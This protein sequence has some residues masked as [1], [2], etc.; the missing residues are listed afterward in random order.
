MCL[1]FKHL[2]SVVRYCRYWRC[3]QNAWNFVRFVDTKPLLKKNARQYRVLL[4]VENAAVIDFEQLRSA[5]MKIGVFDGPFWTRRP[6]IFVVARRENGGRPFYY[7]HNNQFLCS[8]SL[9][10]P[11]RNRAR[12]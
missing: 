12:D 2:E 1:K 6:R 10:P 3:I 4:N 9:V 7:L 11:H 8:I 5:G